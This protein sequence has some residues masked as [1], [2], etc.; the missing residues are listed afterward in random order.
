M[1]SRLNSD[2]YRSFGSCLVSSGGLV[3]EKGIRYS[4]AD[5]DISLGGSPIDP[6]RALLRFGGGAGV[7]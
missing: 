3:V 1:L 6:C 2:V 7:V 5:Q 4:Y